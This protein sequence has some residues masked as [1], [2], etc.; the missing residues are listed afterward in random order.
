MEDDLLEK[1]R[2]QAEK[3]DASIRAAALLRI[4]RAESAGDL[5]QA[6]RT[7][8][9]GLDAIQKL[10]P[11]GRDRLLEEARSVAAAVAPELL[12]EIPETHRF[13]PR[14]FASVHIVQTMVAH[15]HVEAAFHYLIEHDDPS[16]FPF[17]SVAAVL[18]HLNP[19]SPESADRRLSLL[20]H[21]LEMWRKCPPGRRS[22]DRDQFVQVFGRHWT[23]FPADEASAVARMVVDRAVSEPDGAMSARYRN[24]VEFSSTRQHTLFQI[25][26]VLRRLDPAIAQSLLDSHDQLAVAAR[27]YPNGWETMNEEMEAEVKRR[28]ASGAT[29]EG[30]GYILAGN[31]EDFDRQRRLIDAMRSGEFAQSIEDALEKYRED[32]SPDTRNY[33]PKE[34]WPSTGAFRTVFYKAGQRLGV[35]AANLLEQIPD[36]DLRLFA[37]IELAAALAGVPEPRIIQMKQLNPRHSGSFGSGRM[38]SS[39]ARRRGGADAPGIRSPDGRLIRCPKCL[40]EPPDGLRWTCNCGH[41]WNTFWTSGR[42]PACR[43]QWEVT[44]CPGCGETSEHRAWYASES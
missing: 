35:N 6:L 36:D 1:A 30:G 28:Q 25:L 9:E 13:G 18:H 40:F 4:A 23:E 14:Q 15:G 43:F 31:P 3:A 16:S 20:R 11:A 29:C 7:L 37:S 10:S 24:E 44:Q 8:L 5:A 26:H 34:H 32:M 38:I 21:A 33:A 39:A 22:H 17:F 41:S 12:G 42:C 2:R 19:R 27:R